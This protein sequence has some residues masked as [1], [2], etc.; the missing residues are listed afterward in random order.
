MS[1]QSIL[2]IEKAKPAEEAH[3]CKELDEKACTG[4][5]GDTGYKCMWMYQ[6]REP[7]KKTEDSS[8]PYV[9]A[10]DDAPCTDLRSG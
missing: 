9:L 6:C 8:L 1:S 7:D 3:K 5:V 4:E 10:R 2:Q